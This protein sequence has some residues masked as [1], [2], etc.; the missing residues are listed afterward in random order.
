MKRIQIEA[1]YDKYP[2]LRK[3]DVEKIQAWLIT[4]PHLPENTDLEVAIFLF[5]CDFSVEACKTRMDNYYTCRTKM[6]FAFSSRDIAADD[7]DI[8]HDIM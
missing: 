2:K 3:E 6:N 1:L 7:M 4:Q 8:H 5:C